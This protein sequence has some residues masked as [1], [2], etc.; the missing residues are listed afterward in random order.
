MAQAKAKHPD[1][2]SLLQLG[3]I[4]NPTRK[5]ILSTTKFPLFPVEH[6]VCP[7]D[8]YDWWSQ[9]G[10]TLDAFCGRRHR[11]SAASAS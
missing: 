1:S 4:V 10:R 5:V 8:V 9:I 7:H 2:R 11:R 6:S 3:F